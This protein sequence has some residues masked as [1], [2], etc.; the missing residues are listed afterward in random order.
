M[1]E[2]QGKAETVSF[3]VQAIGRQRPISAR[4]CE[5]STD[6]MQIWHLSYPNGDARKIT[7]GLQ[8]Y[9]IQD[10]LSST[11]DSGAIIATQGDST[12]RIWTLGL[13]E[14]A[15]QAKQ[16]TSGKYDGKEGVTC[17]PDERIVYCTVTGDNTN[18]L[19][20]NN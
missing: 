6:D 14:D 20:M 9:K 4:C 3:I 16:I 2:P 10:G 12:L 8:S 18:I 11:A 17:L 7:S 15:S 5:Q 19:V 13:N 1:R